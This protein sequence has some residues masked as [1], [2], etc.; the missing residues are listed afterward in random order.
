MHDIIL[1]GLSSLHELSG[2]QDLANFLRE[3]RPT[4]RYLWEAYRSSVVKISYRK[5][6]L[7]AAYMLRYFPYHAEVTHVVLDELYMRGVLPFQEELLHVNLFGCG[8]APELCGIMQ[9]LKS[10]FPRT[11][12]LITHL[13][14]VASESWRYSRQITLDY[15]VPSIMDKK[16]FEAHPAYFDLTRPGS[17]VGFFTPIDCPN[18]I[19]EA[20]L[21]MF[22]NCL[23][24]FSQ[25]VYDMVIRN[26]LDLLWMMKVGK[27]MLVIDRSGY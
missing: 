13:F 18:R 14:D 7:Q 2:E 8:P 17:A 23:N 15:L 12:K 5:P 11:K 27:I 16:L 22:Q 24:E 9:L 6:A 25:S 20:S 21:V 10:R 1:K 26:T 3:L 4:A 19:S